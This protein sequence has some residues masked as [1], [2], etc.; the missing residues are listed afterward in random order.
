MKEISDNLKFITGLKYLYVSGIYNIYLGNKI[1]DE[2][3][4]ELSNNLCF[5]R[6]IERLY[7]DSI[8]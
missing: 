3:I 4:I 6:K 1:G 7:I 8:L 5:V 2:G